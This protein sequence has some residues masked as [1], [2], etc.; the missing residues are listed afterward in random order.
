MRVPAIF[1]KGRH[2]ENTTVQIRKNTS[3][4]IHNELT[5]GGVPFECRMQPYHALAA[6]TPSRDRKFMS[7]INRRRSYLNGPLELVGRA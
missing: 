3:A 6:R 1:G 7:K 4:L 2:A 5:P